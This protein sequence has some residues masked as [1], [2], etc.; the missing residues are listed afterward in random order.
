[1]KDLGPLADKIIIDTT[2]PVGFGPEGVTMAPIDGPSGAALIAAAADGGRMV[3]TLNQVGFNIMA[4]PS[5]GA[6]TPVMFVAGDSAEAKSVAADLVGQ[7]GFDA[8]DAGPLRN[9][10]ALEHLALLWIDQA[11]RGPNGRD[12]A[13]S[14][15]PIPPKKS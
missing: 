14:L 7:L 10:A 8:K 13:L 4:S 9:A 11:M 1:V 2:N 6:A 5:A 3:K 15:T 12:F